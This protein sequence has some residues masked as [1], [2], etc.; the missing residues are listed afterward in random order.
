VVRDPTLTTAESGPSYRH[1]HPTHVSSNR[2]LRCGR[3]PAPVA[4]S[5]SMK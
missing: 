4:S 1:G 3:S 2:R 5:G